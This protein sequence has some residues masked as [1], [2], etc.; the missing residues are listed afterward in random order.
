MLDSVSFVAEA[1][2]EGSGRWR[3]GC[4]HGFQ[5]EVASFSS[6]IVGAAVEIIVFVLFCRSGFRI[7]S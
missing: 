7:N 3:V 5:S 1:F 2:C 4:V 6:L